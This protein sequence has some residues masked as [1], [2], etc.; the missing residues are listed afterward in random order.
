VLL[1]G[2]R[3]Y[4]QR[5][6]IATSVPVQPAPLPQMPPSTPLPPRP[7]STP[8]AIQQVGFTD[9]PAQN[10]RLPPTALLNAVHHEQPTP[11]APSSPQAAEPS[12]AAVSVDVVGPE[13][14]TLGQPFT[15]EIVLRNSGGRILA[16]V[17]IEQPLPS[18]GR[19]LQSDPPARA[20]TKMLS[21]DLQNLD[22]GAQR[23]LKVQIQPGAAGDWDMRPSV[24]FKAGPARTRVAKPPFTVEMSADHPSVSRGE[25]ITFTI[26]L[27][28]NSAE[29]LK[30]IQLY[31]TLPA[32]LQHPRGDKIVARIGD[33]APGDTRT[34]TLETSAIQTGTFANK[35]LAT[36]EQG[37]EASAHV[38]VVITELTLALHV[39]GP[40]QSITQQELDF[41]LDV[42]NPGPIA[43]KNVRVVQALPPSFVTVAASS[44]ANIDTAQQALVWSLPDLASGQ[45]QTLTFR[46][47]GSQSGD[48]P[49]VTA[50]LTDTLPEARVTSKIHLDAAAALKLE[51]RAREGALAVAGETTYVMHVFN[52]G[53]AACTGLQL[54]A[55]LPPEVTPLDA[56]GPSAGKIEGQQVRFATLE[57]LPARA[58]A[59]YT[60]RVRGQKAGQATVRAEL[61]AA[62]QRPVQK[63]MSIQ[64]T[65]LANPEIAKSAT[66]EKLRTAR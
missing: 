36:A 62:G 42:S 23:R 37:I 61:A 33:L 24:T 31:D 20:D 65:G 59:R 52:H 29:P 14:L 25:H 28:N 1:V 54:T 22:V 18:G 13:R 10:T 46:V 43:A 3:A 34:I 26:R 58:D 32:G 30:A 39:D 17:H 66:D 19:L 15:Q 7:T 51:L 56:Q 38:E 35:V 50:V 9:N 27:S 4:G 5:E 49:L 47:K 11:P 41:H 63:E 45:R 64:I 60:V 8:G 53:D 44:G 48:W 16:E 6:V 57:K 2:T 55:T 12:A 21:W 40:R